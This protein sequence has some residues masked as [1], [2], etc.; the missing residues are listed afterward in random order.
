MAASTTL[1]CSNRI[2]SSRWFGPQSQPQRPIRHCWRLQDARAPV[3]CDAAARSFTVR[4][5]TTAYP[6]QSTVIGKSIAPIS[7]TSPHRVQVSYKDEEKL[8]Y[9][10]RVLNYNRFN[11]ITDFPNHNLKVILRNIP[12]NSKVYLHFFG[13]SSRTECIIEC[14]ERRSWSSGNGQYYWELC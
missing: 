9:N 4:T 11:I 12:I 6:C 13:I 1:T 3:Q 14:N 7:L 5:P 8:N 2:D 10:K